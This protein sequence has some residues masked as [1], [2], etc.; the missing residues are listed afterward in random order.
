MTEIKSISYLVY[1]LVVC[2]DHYFP[3]WSLQNPLNLSI[4]L[5]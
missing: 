1:A 5:S 3:T 2:T 4:S